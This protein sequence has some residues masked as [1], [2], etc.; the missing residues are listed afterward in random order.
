MC[1]FALEK[2]EN[3]KKVLYSTLIVLLGC[4]FVSSCDDDE[5]Y[6]EQKEK[7]NKD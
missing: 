4:M 5:T 1:I 7:E 2:K 6:A 3:M